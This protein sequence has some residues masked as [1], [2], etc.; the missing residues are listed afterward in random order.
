MRSVMTASFGFAA[1]LLLAPLPPLPAQ[2]PLAALEARVAKLEGQIEAKDLVG[3]YRVAAF[4]A[5]PDAPDASNPPQIAFGV[6]Y[7][8][9][10]LLDGGAAL[11]N[12]TFQGTSL[13]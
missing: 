9:V 4:L 3:E 8:T 13:F 7:G 12:G 6:A 1:A 10:R 11:L 5:D 2:S